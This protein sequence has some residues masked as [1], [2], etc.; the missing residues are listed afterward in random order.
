MF[1]VLELLG[2]SILIEFHHLCLPQIL[3]TNGLVVVVVVV[4]VSMN[5][6]VSLQF[7]ALACCYLRFKNYIHGLPFRQ[8]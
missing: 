3:G 2:L 8:R 7:D 5:S 1:L 4:V 6:M